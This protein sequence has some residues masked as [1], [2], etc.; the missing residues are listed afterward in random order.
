MTPRD[1]D[2]EWFRSSTWNDQV[3]AAFE[4]KLRRARAGSRAQYLHIQGLHLVDQD[5][6]SAQTVG[7]ALLRRV[8]DEHGASDPMRAL[9]ARQD[10]ALSLVR[11]GRSDEAEPLLRDLLED[12]HSNPDG[13]RGDYGVLELALAELLQHRGTADEL[14]EAEAWLD[15][16]E[17]DIAASGFLRDLVLRFLV[18]RARVARDRGDLDRAGVFAAEALAVGD[19]SSPPLSRHPA[20][21]RV[22]LHAD[23]RRELESIR[24]V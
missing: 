3:A 12:R 13:W 15:L 2:T 23:L 17:A 19:E 8:I 16:G 10:L 22:E 18:A 5:D 24:P 4:V 11:R 14:E 7:L 21:G 9:W 6:E 20:V 1:D